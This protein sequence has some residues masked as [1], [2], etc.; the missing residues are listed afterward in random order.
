MP[1]ETQ[2][3][4]LFS[5][6]TPR[7]L[8]LVLVALVVVS[9]VLNLWIWTRTG[10]FDW[11]DLPGSLGFLIMGIGGITDPAFGRRYQTLYF[12]AAGL[13]IVNLIMVALR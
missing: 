10:R 4:G 13:I 12:V 6:R 1:V 3:P 7:A 8:H 5:Q 2:S 9:L 11:T